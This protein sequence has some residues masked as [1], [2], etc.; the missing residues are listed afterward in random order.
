M[1]PIL[2]AVLLGELSS[3]AALEAADPAPMQAASPTPVAL[4]PLPAPMSVP[5]P[6]PK[7]DAP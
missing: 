2:I 7:T 3:G 1:S 4:P 5:K 6:G